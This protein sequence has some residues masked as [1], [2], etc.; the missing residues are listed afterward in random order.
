MTTSPAPLE[1]IRVLDLSQIWAGPWATQLLGSLGAEIIKIESTVRMDPWRGPLE[2]TGPKHRYPEGEPGTDPYNRDAFYNSM[3]RNKLGITLDLT[4]PEG[5]ELFRRLVAVSDVVF[6][7]FRSGQMDKFGLGWTELS[8]IR[9]E[10]ILVSLPG[11]GATGPYKDFIAWGPVL[12]AVCG[13]AGLVGYS[14]GPP[15]LSGSAYIDA[16]SGAGACAAILTALFH[17]RRSGRG[18]Y[19]DVSQLEM[20]TTFVAPVLLEY[21]FRGTVPRRQGTASE[22]FAPYGC[23]RCR[24]E[25]QWIAIAVESDHDWARFR[26]AAEDPE[27]TRAETFQTVL[28]RSEHRDEL[29]RLVES[30]TSVRDKYEAMTTLQAAGVVAGALLDAGELMRDPHFVARKFFA[31]VPHPSAGTYTYPGMPFFLGDAGQ[32]EWRPA[33]RLGEHN[34]YV[35][36][37]LLGLSAD[38]IRDLTDKGIVGTRPVPG[39]QA[40]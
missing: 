18:V 4:K 31:D 1:G 11:F 33:P 27:W 6:E 3:N 15:I 23:F 37:E 26:E 19:V 28:G 29:H 8:A 22:V 21:Q 14:D 13:M 9:P 34:D 10:I 25:D 30:W 32:T 5:K 38:T 12:E 7:N 16:I 2:P 40:Y 35:F 36:R 39:K 17:R 24:G 20:A